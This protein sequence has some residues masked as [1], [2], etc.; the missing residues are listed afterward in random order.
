MYLRYIFVCVVSMYLCVCT[1]VC[2]CGIYQCVYMCVHMYLCMCVFLF[3]ARRDFFRVQLSSS[4]WFD[5]SHS[6]NC[7]SLLSLFFEER[8]EKVPKSFWKG[9]SSV[10]HSWRFTISQIFCCLKVTS[11]K[12][13]S[14]MEQRSTLEANES[15]A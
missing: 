7:I 6:L 14:F 8:Q 12:R 15:F 10:T 2:I 4:R 13:K 5:I 11:A 9:S 1:C 3:I